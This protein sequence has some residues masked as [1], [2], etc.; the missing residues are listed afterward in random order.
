MIKTLQKIP[1]TWIWDIFRQ[2]PNSVSLNN[3]STKYLQNL[4]KSCNLPVGLRKKCG[5]FLRGEIFCGLCLF[6]TS[7][8]AA[9][10]EATP[11]GVMATGL[12]PIKH[13]AVTCLQVLASAKWRLVVECLM[14][15]HRD[16]RDSIWLLASLSSSKI[17]LGN[18]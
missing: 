18:E 12:P 8:L 17:C 6:K 2:P 16:L 15:C 1:N 11:L 7:P 9:W 13:T 5:S 10:P 14:S 4:Y 3:Y